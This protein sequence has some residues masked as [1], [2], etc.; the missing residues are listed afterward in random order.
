MSKYAMLIDYGYCTG[1][2]SCEISCRNEKGLELHEWG[3]RVNELGPEDFNGTWEWDY[4]PA[5]SRLCN[6]CEELIDQGKKAPCALHCLADV[7][8]I[9]RIEEVSQRMAELDRS[10]IV[11]YVP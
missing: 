10:K 2:R 1:C 11:C 6:L 4:L 8:D 9:V 5:P 7:I 3:I